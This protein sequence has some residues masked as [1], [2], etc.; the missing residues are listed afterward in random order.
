M[1]GQVLH[2]M[3]GC[4]TLWKVC[5]KLVSLFQ[6]GLNEEVTQVSWASVYA[7]GTFKICLKT[8]VWA[9]VS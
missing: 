1:N 5:L 8:E 6:F 7:I 3:D 2:L 9:G 4:V